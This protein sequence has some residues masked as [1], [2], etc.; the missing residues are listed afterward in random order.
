MANQSVAGINNWSIF[1]YPGLSKLPYDIRMMRTL[2]DL[3]I[4]FGFA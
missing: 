4:K 2:T 3:S 1:R